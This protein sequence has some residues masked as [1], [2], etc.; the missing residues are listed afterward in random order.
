MIPNDLLCHLI[1]YRIHASTNVLL[2]RLSS[3]LHNIYHFQFHVCSL[4][5]QNHIKMPFISDLY[6]DYFAKYHKPF[7]LLVIINT[8]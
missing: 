2:E 4:K 7:V 6:R 8:H 5:I 3:I 1:I